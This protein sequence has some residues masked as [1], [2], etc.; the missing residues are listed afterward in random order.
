MWRSTDAV[1]VM[2][3]IG[4]DEPRAVKTNESRLGLR[5][6]RSRDGVTDNPHGALKSN[7]TWT[8]ENGFD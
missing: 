7:S 3:N 8:D 1:K 2:R 5:G 4:G 6:P